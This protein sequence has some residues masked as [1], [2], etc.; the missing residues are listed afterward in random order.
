MTSINLEDGT[1]LDLKYLVKD[2]DRRGNDRIY[3]RRH[4]RKVRIRELATVEEF[5][6]AY[7]AALEAPDRS[8]SRARRSHASH[9]VVPVPRPDRCGQNRTVQGPG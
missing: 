5:M 2:T 9:R 3:V 8:A 4:G 1:G 6:A 7:R